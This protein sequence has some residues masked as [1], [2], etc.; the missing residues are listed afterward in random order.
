MRL[1]SL[2]IPAFTAALI[3]FSQVSSSSSH[4]PIYGSQLMT[5]QERIEHRDKLRNAKTREEREQ[6]RLEHHEKM[7]ERARAQGITLPDKPPASGG[8]MGPGSG[9]GPGGRGGR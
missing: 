2:I 6:I 1:R 8:S 4:G 9:M 5:E 7:K 3:L